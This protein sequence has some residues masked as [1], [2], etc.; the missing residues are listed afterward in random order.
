MY[1]LVQPRDAGPKM[2]EHA[3]VVGEFETLE[4]AYAELE[5][6]AARLRERPEL[7]PDRVDLYVVDE[8]RKPVL[9][10]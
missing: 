4:A 3:M 5:R 6:Y 2:F 7:P 1:L 9:S 8:N 10:G